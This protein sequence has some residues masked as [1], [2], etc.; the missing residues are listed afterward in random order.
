MVEIILG[1]ISAAGTVAVAIVGSRYAR[2][3]KKAEKRAKIRA[4]ESQLAMRLI[5]GIGELSAA[6]SIA[7]KENRVNGEM[8]KAL[9]KVENAQ[10]EYWQ[11]INEIAA[12]QLTD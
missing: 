9:I 10:G 11:H 2:D 4:K 6:N 8:D 1:V 3:S 7:I 12:E 5:S